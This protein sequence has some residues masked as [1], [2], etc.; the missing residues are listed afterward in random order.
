MKNIKNIVTLLFL[1]ISISLLGQTKI[2][3]NKSV[4]NWKGYK[5][6]GFHE[7]TINLKAGELLFKDNQLIGG[8]FV[9]DMTS[10]SSTDI[11][12]RGKERLDVHLKNEDF[13][14]VEKHPESSLIFTKV[15]KKKK[16]TYAVTA[17]LVI[18]GIK[19]IVQ[20][21]FNVSQNS[22]STSFEIDRTKFDIKYRSK[23]IFPDLADKAIKDNFDINV[24]LVF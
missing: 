17:D 11:S 2:D 21:D 14:D 13:F 10:I 9:V 15:V 24:E 16:G 3:I 20:F 7:G 22:A 8:K 23:T 4:V 5:V 18:K 6:A 1:G 12:G 19:Q